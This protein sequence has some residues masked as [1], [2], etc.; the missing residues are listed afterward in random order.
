MHNPSAI[1][2]YTTWEKH[3]VG[4]VLPEKFFSSQRVTGVHLQIN[5]Q[6]AVGLWGMGVESKGCLQEMLLLS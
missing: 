3:H 5:C 6:V 1:P 2:Y 4:P